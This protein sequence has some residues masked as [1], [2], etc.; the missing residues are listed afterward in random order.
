MSKA[1]HPS[2]VWLPSAAAFGIAAQMLLLTNSAGAPAKWAACALALLGG[3]MVCL[4]ARLSRTQPRPLLEMLLVSGSL[5]G[6]G[7]FVGSMLDA[8]AVVPRSGVVPPC[9]AAVA[10]QA[11]LAMPWLG[12]DLVSN[13]NWMNGLM[14]VA[15]VGGCML[16]CPR[17]VPCQP[18][19]YLARCATQGI[20]SVGMLLGMSLG[21]RLGSAPL[22]RTFG[23]SGGMHLAMLGGMLLGTALVWPLTKIVISR[24]NNTDWLEINA[25]HGDPTTETTHDTN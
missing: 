8:G 15:C 6:L 23:A 4:T 9:H 19:D 3:A 11:L 1:I 7:M 18:R 16:L 25:L 2:S 10:P 14:L 20:L 21:G 12:F 22:G 24:T 17:R 13:M 5:G